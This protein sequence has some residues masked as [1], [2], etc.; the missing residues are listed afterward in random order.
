MNALPSNINAASARLPQTYEAAK[1]ALANCASLD[2]CQDWADKAAALASYARQADDDQLE[3]M[4]V[5][6]R[7]RAVRRCGELL[8]QFDARPANASK[9][10]GDT[11]TLISQREAAGRAGLSKD[12]QVTAV[13]V[14]NIPEA[15]FDDQVESEAPPTITA[16]ARQGVKPMAPKAVPDETPAMMAQAPIIDLKGRPPGEFNQAMHYLGPIREYAGELERMDHNGVLPILDERERNDLRA[17]ISKIDTI[18]D[19]IVT[20]I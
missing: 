17:I 18:H 16:L 4:A 12:Q 1:T 19:M 8:K 6:I 3:K 15:V 20:R 5:R 2:E 9:Q 11:P 14:A 7:A 10:S 13:R